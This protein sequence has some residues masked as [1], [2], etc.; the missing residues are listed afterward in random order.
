MKF[1]LC[2]TFFWKRNPVTVSFCKIF[3]TTIALSIFSILLFFETYQ[4]I[5][6]EYWTIIYGRWFWN[7]GQWIWGCCSRDW[8]QGSHRPKCS[9]ELSH[10]IHINR[11]NCIK[12]D[13]HIF[14]TFARLVCEEMG[15]FG[16]EIFIGT[17]KS[18]VDFMTSKKG[19]PLNSEIL[20]FES[21]V[22]VYDV[23]CFEF[24]LINNFMQ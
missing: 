1:V 12:N 4:T 22:S 2:K 7:G 18:Y 20:K 13:N 9:S 15:F 3:T 21:L 10:E 11:I 5:K 23:G 17:Q 19:I 16:E 8:W 6:L 24:S 14:K